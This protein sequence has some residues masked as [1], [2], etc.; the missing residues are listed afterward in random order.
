MN[1]VRVAVVSLACVATF[2]LAGCSSSPT[3]QQIGTGVGAVAGG[4][5]GDAVFGNTLGTVG[6]AAAGAV[7]GN[8]IGKDRDDRRRY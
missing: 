4:V 8:Q 3:N 7:I 6:G 2:G 5:V 1:K